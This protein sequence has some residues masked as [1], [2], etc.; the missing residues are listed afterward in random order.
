MQRLCSSRNVPGTSFTNLDQHD[1]IVVTVVSVCA[2]IHHLSIRVTEHTHHVFGGKPESLD[3]KNPQ[4]VHIKRPQVERKPRTV[5]NKRTTLPPILTLKIVFKNYYNY[6][7][8]LH[9]KSQKIEIKFRF[10]I[11]QNSDVEL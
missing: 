4:N 8:T 10:L 7:K 11:I 1:I 5:G 3:K 2:E 9:I 6:N